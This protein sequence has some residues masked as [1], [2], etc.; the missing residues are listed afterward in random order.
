MHF[1]VQDN[2]EVRLDTRDILYVSE[3]CRVPSIKA[4]FII[5][6][7]NEVRLDSRDSL[8]IIKTHSVVMFELEKNI[9]S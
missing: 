9:F 4:H 6:L 7:N 3:G 5:V 8:Y 2:D 1:I